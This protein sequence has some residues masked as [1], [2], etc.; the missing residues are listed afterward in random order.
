MRALRLRT[1][2]TLLVVT[3]TV[4][5]FLIVGIAILGFR[6]P[7]IEERGRIQSQEAATHAARLLDQFLGGVE[8]QLAPLVDLID[9]QP[10]SMAQTFMDAIVAEG[11]TFDALSILC[12]NGRI[13]AISLPQ[14][15]RAFDQ[16]LLGA[17]LSANR[18]FIRARDQDGLPV[19]SDGFLSLL[20][21]KVTVGLA[22]RSGQ[23]MVVGEL[24]QQRLLRLL[25]GFGRDGETWVLVVD[26]RGRWLGATIQQEN[27]EHFNYGALPLFRAVVAGQPL[28]PDEEIWGNRHLVGGVISDKLGWV[29][30]AGIPAG[31]DNYAYRTTTLLVAIGFFGSLAIAF[32]LA[33]IWAGWMARPIRRLIE[34]AHSIAASDYADA[35]PARGPIMELNQLSAD[36]GI[37]ARAIREREEGMARSAIEIRQLNAELEERVA[38]RT[39]ELS[40]A[41]A[42]LVATVGNLTA[43]QEQLVQ[44]E[45]LAALGNLVAGVAHE[46]NTPIGNALLATSTLAD[47]LKEF[48]VTMQTGL[49]RSDLDNLLAT[50]ATASDIGAR[51]LYLAADLVTSFKQVAV[52]QT[53]AQRRTFDLAEVIREIVLTL[54]P[55]F[56]HTP[57]QIETK[58]PDDLTLDSYPGALGQVLTNL[59]N[60]ALLHGFEGREQGMIRIEAEATAG[61]K[62]KLVVRD[63]GRGISADR[64]KRVFEP[65]FTTRLGHGGSGLGLHIVFNMVTGVLGGVL[66]LNS[67][68]GVGTEITLLLPRKAPQ[69]G[70]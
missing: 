20:S 17:D 5:A 13:V 24:S 27:M 36:L 68:E 50:I 37:T 34:Y 1:S 26:N 4:L 39:A 32:L 60:N 44:S 30:A 70:A 69:Q 62:I 52:D 35:P 64:Q 21:G 55:T 9:Q 38:R 23:Y 42:E 2:L 14:H 65:F 8:E 33:P 28:P 41:N 6:L 46:L 66:S 58:V 67:Q 49:R 61:E 11:V 63:N 57:F 54:Q 12:G 25:D 16:E 56:K 3:A 43:A 7:Q 53:G 45:K 40:R 51:N 48:R 10:L 31:W 59:I 15:R 19:W 18:L 29:F 22:M 47:R